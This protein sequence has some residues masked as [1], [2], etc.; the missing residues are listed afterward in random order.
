[1]TYWIFEMA[2][3]HQGSV[4]H[5]KKIIYE[6]GML[7]DSMGIRAGIK[8]QFRQLDTFIHPEWRNSDLK[9]VKRFLETKLDKKQ[10]A[11]IVKTI[12][13]ANLD[14]I[15]TPFDNESL[16]WFE[17]FGINI[18]KVASCST[19]DWPL[20]SAIASMKKRT[21][22][23]TGGTDISTLRTVNALFNFAGVDYSFLHCVGEYPTP[24]ECSNLSRID[25]LAKEFPG[26]EIGISTHEGPNQE[27]IV[28][29]AV[30]LGAKIVEKHVGVETD[31]IKLNAYSCNSAQMRNV[32]A[33][34]QS[35]ENAMIGKSDKE[36]DSLKKLKRGVYAAKHIHEGDV[37]KESDVFYAMPCQE[38]Q[39]DVSMV[40]QILN[41]PAST[42]Y[43]AMSPIRVTPDLSNEIEKIKEFFISSAHSYDIKL[44]KND[45]CEI[46]CHYGIKNFDAVGAL[47]VTK[48]N[49]DYCKKLIFMKER[50]AHPSHHHVQK[51]ETFE[52]LK[53]DCTLILNGKSINME[54]GK[55]Y[56][57]SRGVEH[58]FFTNAGCVI[59]EISTTHVKGDSVYKDPLITATHVDKR[60]IRFKL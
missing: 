32:I 22:I 41:Y 19:D 12:R 59:E 40:N 2:N 7:A 28:P 6:F 53:G 1:M 43:K 13:E 44:H 17:D 30:A 39:A 45:D 50:Q 25:L 37:V 3:N 47:I 51:E 26:I 29:Y 34:T 18:I 54:L 58:E 38:G 16:L 9:Y 56:V 24:I 46:S 36:A 49:R 10:F 4:D 52:L 27:S 5:A 55:P 35:I 48:V 60:K 20:L 11:E 15:A 23:S 57:I 33:M 31:L 14:V 8:L 21:I 42:S